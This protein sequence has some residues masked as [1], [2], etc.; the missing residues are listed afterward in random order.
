MHPSSPRAF[1]PGPNLPFPIATPTNKLLQSIIDCS[2][3][4]DASTLPCLGNDLTS[5]LRQ[6]PGSE[7]RWTACLAHPIGSW[8]PRMQCVVSAAP[9][10]IRVE[11]LDQR[12]LIWRL[13]AQVIP[14]VRRG[15]SAR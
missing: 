11:T 4:Y 9:S 7:L 15:C 13:S 12:D 2:M 3:L 1:V 14:L 5:I 10:L 6:I 8:N